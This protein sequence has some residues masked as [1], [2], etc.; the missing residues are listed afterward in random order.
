[1]SVTGVSDE[2]LAP[3][4]GLIICMLPCM[5]A[6]QE[7]F[8][9]QHQLEFIAYIAILCCAVFFARRE[10]LNQRDRQFIPRALSDL[11]PA[12]HLLLLSVFMLANFAV[13]RLVYMLLTGHERWGLPN[14]VDLSGLQIHRDY[15]YYGL[16]LAFAIAVI[17]H[18]RRIERVR[19]HFNLKFR[20]LPIDI[21]I[22]IGLLG[23]TFGGLYL[24][25]QYF[26]DSHS[27]WFPFGIDPTVSGQTK[28]LIAGGL[29][30]LVNALQEEL[31]FR[32]ILL[33][34]LQ[35]MMRGRWQILLA[36]IVFGIVHWFGTPQGVIGLLLAGSW[37]ILLS[38]WTW[39]RR[40][41]WPAFIVHV[42]ADWLIFAYTAAK[43]GSIL[44]N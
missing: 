40:S 12:G 42:F 14:L 9:Q 44:A 5:A 19:F 16:Q 21:L 6:L 29:F 34:S 30:A 2:R 4:Y 17:I 36:G 43:S 8:W 20:F 13:V 31:W 22:T 10:Y 24:Y 41:L 38:A 15:I 28:F 37:G 1:M 11:D 18:A 23:L 26:G 39:R 35:S 32:G 25:S 33:G 3:I 7:F 27:Q